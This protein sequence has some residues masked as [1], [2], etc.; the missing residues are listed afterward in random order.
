MYQQGLFLCKKEQLEYIL[1]R[2][3]TTIFGQ[4]KRNAL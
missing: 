3:F 4:T 2:L 1:M